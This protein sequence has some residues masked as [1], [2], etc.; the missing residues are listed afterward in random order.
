MAAV[1][2]LEE[3]HWR[4]HYDPEHNP[5]EQ[6]AAVAVSH[7]WGLYELSPEHMSLEQVFVDITR[8]DPTEQVHGD[9]QGVAA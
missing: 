9:E 5:A 4:I 1:E 7:D 8:S 6:L 3:G 2:A